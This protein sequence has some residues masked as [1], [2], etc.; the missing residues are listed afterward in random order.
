MF[1]SDSRWRIDWNGFIEQ[2]DERGV[3]DV[4]Y[5][6]LGTDV[7]DLAIGLAA[8]VLERGR[9]AVDRADARRPRSRTTRPPCRPSRR[10]NRRRARAS[11]RWT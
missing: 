9:D 3:G 2:V 1:G 10:P 7:D 6:R 4:D 8:D 5:D 11:R